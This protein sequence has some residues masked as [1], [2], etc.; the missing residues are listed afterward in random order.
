[1]S[2]GSRFPIPEGVIEVTDDYQLNLAFFELKNLK[3]KGTVLFSGE[4][5]DVVFQFYC[6]ETREEG[7]YAKVEGN[8]PPH[9]KRVFE[10]LE[11][12]TRMEAFITLNLLQ[13]KMVFVAPR[14]QLKFLPGGQRVLRFDFPFKILKTHRRKFIRIPFNEQFP[15]ELRFQ[16][17]QGTQVRK[18]KDLSREGMKIALQPGDESFIQ[19]GYRPKQA[20]LKVLNREMA[21]GLAVMAVQGTSSAGAKIIAISEED[22]LWIRDCIRILMRQILKI[23]EQPVDDEIKDSGSGSGTE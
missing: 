17:E 21:V 1:M 12:Y 4:T 13:F 10:Y 18:L 8:M 20:V 11:R 19:V 14:T 23:N 6:G 7:I 3:P 9:A 22:K 2:L 5:K 16:T 15:A